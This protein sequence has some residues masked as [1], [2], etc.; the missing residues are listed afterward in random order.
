M[1]SD[2][3]GNK[4]NVL[5]NDFYEKLPQTIVKKLKKEGAIS[6]CTLKSI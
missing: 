6:G 5:K 3:F 4:T 1:R 2:I